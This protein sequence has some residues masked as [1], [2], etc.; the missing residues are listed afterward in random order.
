LAFPGNERGQARKGVVC[1]LTDAGEIVSGIDSVPV[2]T[3]TLFP[4]QN[5]NTIEEI[6]QDGLLLLKFSN[7][8]SRKEFT[9]KEDI[10]GI[11]HQP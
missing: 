7:S 4:K 2:R 11:T 5:T 3:A 1:V 9:L 6:K 8:Q 10:T